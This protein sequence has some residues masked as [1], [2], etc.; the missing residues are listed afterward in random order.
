MLCPAAVCW[1]H[2][3]EEQQ[4][5]PAQKPPRLCSGDSLVVPDRV[6]TTAGLL[7]SGQ[8]QARPVHTCCNA[9]GHLPAWGQLGQ[10]LSC[11]SAGPAMVSPVAPASAVGHH[12]HTLHKTCMHAPRLWSDCRSAVVR[13]TAMLAHMRTSPIICDSLLCLY[14]C[15]QECT[16]I[17]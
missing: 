2:Q 17:W 12:G 4:E 9:L 10:D 13:E 8:D 11:S 6:S 3:G 16:C 15:L 1:A 7:R 5:H 14:V